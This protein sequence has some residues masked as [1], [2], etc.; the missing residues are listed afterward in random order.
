[1]QIFLNVG[2]ISFSF[3][4]VLMS[5]SFFP[6]QIILII[7]TLIVASLIFYRDKKKISYKKFY[8]SYHKIKKY[9]LFILKG[10]LPYQ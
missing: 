1:V 5:N 10:I 6:E 3:T 8:D 2:R 7:P 4:E 9:E